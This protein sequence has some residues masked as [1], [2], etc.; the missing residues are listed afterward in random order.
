MSS[1]HAQRPLGPVRAEPVE[2]CRIQLKLERTGFSLDVD[3]KLPASGITAIFGASG[4]GKTTLLRCVAGLERARDGLVRIGNEVWQDDAQSRFV[5]T[6]QRHLGVVFQEPSLFE[7]LDVEGNLRFG[8]RRA[9]QAVDKSAWNHL[10]ELMGI[11]TLL[12]RKPHTLSGGERQRVAIARALMPQPRLL[13]LDEPL[14]AIDQ[15]RKDE[16]LPWLE[17]LR[18]ELS[19]P[20]LYVSHSAAEVARLARTLVVMQQ[21][22]VLAAGPIETVY[23]SAAARAAFGD[24][25][26]VLMQGRVAEVDRRYAL[27]RLAVDGA[28]S[29]WLRDENFAVGQPLRVRVLARDVSLATEEPRGTSLQNHW[30]GRI[31]AIVPERH[32][33]QA[34]VRVQCGEAVLAAIVTRRAVDQLGLAPG[35]PVWAQVKSVALVH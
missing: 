5:P 34:L 30:H 22:R 20:M 9:A 32:P 18:D 28:A 26:G 35:M 21:G 33:S 7:H 23:G 8:L 17:R 25:A 12:P 29:L 10:I 2:A 27:A 11:G 6:W 3:L 1:V 24:E 31:E 15:A 14:A 13:L 16:I 19:I 4:A